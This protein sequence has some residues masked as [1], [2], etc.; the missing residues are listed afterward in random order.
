LVQIK[1]LPP[2]GKTFPNTSMTTTP[3]Q[4]I[5][6]LTPCSTDGVP[7]PGTQHVSAVS[8]QS[9]STVGRAGK[10]KMIG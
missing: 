2:I 6:P 9:K 3:S 8:R 7:Y 5:A 10:L 4:P 1:H